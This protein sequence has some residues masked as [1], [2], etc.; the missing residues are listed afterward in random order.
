[1]C[2]NRMLHITTI[3]SSLLQVCIGGGS[4]LKVGYFPLLTSLF[5]VPP[6]LLSSSTP[7]PFCPSRYLP[8]PSRKCIL[9]NFFVV[10]CK[11]ECGENRLGLFM[12]VQM[13]FFFHFGAEKSGRGRV[14]NMACPLGPK[15]GYATACPTQ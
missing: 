1:M 5:L 8:S 6:L 3:R 4:F 11:G 14:I 15:S 12:S 10:K 2:N 9:V 13:R 7:S